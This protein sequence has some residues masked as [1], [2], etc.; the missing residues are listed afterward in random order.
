MLF[1]KKT[2]ELPEFS[3]CKPTTLK[4]IQ[5]WISSLPK[6]DTQK[7][8]EPLTSACK[9]ILSTECSNEQLLQLVE[10][11]EEITPAAES[12][13]TNAKSNR[14]QSI[15]QNNLQR[16]FFLN[17]GLLYSDL[18]VRL[19]QTDNIK[20]I[21]FITKGLECLSKVILISKQSYTEAPAKCW[22]T[23]HN[24]YYQAISNLNNKNNDDIQVINAFYKSSILL[25]CANT[26]KLDSGSITQLY[27]W[28]TKNTASIK[29]FA[30]P[31]KETVFFVNISEDNPPQNI[32]SKS[33]A[34]DQSLMGSKLFFS[35]IGLLD[36]E[37]LKEL[38]PL[39]ATHLN[40]VIGGKCFRTEKR[41]PSNK[42]LKICI[43]ISEL[44]YFIAEKKS[45]KNFI[46]KVTALDQ[47]NTNP[48]LDKPGQKDKTEMDAWQS[49]Y[50]AN[51]DNQEGSDFVI[52][53]ELGNQEEFIDE[54]VYH[55][56]DSKALNESSHGFC[57]SN[58]D[59][60]GKNIV[61]GSLL[62]LCNDADEKQWSACAIRWVKNNNNEKKM[63]IEIFS[64]HPFP[65][66][67]KWLHTKKNTDYLPAIILTTDEI[68]PEENIDNE[69]L[70]GCQLL[71][72]NTGPNHKGSVMMVL[73]NKEK[74][75]LVSD[76]IEYSKDFSVYNIVSIID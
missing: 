54:T 66:A 1:Q 64:D 3:F 56:H 37:N 67:I 33:E 51:W 39:V 73:Q 50:Q 40:N 31:N 47:T 60:F 70:K 11:F 53:F 52:E 7:L 9:E 49:V 38:D 23:L 57:L 26:E 41:T 55:S 45:F 44:H 62:G 27:D 19:L 24:T 68:K 76:P 8:V 5:S 10:I 48:F 58:T 13:L 69:T 36:N 6:L 71:A 15:N 59:L 17:F 34:L 72:A 75:I 74:N 16:D 18:G 14:P 22:L 30:E 61:P 63:G 42:D 4:N 20:V 29:A 12:L 46:N 28:A 21:H 32:N 65:A 2:V 35:F 43:G 25:G